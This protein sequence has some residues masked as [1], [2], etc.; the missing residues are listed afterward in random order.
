MLLLF[1]VSIEILEWNLVIFLY[2]VV[3]EEKDVIYD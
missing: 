3:L 1:L 2:K